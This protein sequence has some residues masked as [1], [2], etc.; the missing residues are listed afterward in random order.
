[1]RGNKRK[2]LSFAQIVCHSFAFAFPRGSGLDSRQ[3]R[4]QQTLSVSP[5][6]ARAIPFGIYIAFLVVESLLPREGLGFDLRWLYAVKIV[7]VAIALGW[8][9]NRYSELRA[10]PKTGVGSW[11]LS[12]AVGVV[13]FVVWIV[14]DQPWAVMGTP[15]GW[16]PA[17][18]SGEISW[19]LVAVRL[20]GAVAVVP[21]MEELFWRSL[22][23]RWTR[24]SD[25]LS[26]APAHAGAV[27][28]I[29]SSLLF[30]LEHH[31]WLAGIIAGLAYAGTY[32]RTGNLWCA[33]VAHAVS[34]LLLGV[35]VVQT[36]QWQFW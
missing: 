7:C 6:L 22:V 25:F 11:A 4:T 10:Q 28:L 1:M 20:A 26:V 13:I 36:G 24:N 17:N 32:M 12:L 16:N 33:V 3:Q 30:G 5:A 23:L 35:W 31:E 34:N 27:A 18:S 29:V 9:W 2:T 14:L 15:G 21:V 19:A 8:L